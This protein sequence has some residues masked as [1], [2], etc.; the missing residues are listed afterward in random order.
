MKVRKATLDNDTFKPI[1]YLNCAPLNYII[2]VK[3]NRYRT[4]L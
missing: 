4:T 3:I 2:T 1:I